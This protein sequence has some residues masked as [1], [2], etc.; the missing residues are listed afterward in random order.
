VQVAEAD[1][2]QL[3]GATQSATDLKDF[4]DAGYDP[5]TNKVEGVKLV[6][7]TT[8]NTDMLSTADID[9]RLAAINLDHL[10]TITGA[11]VTDVSNSFDTF[12][13]N[14]AGGTN[15]Y[16]VG[17]KILFLDGDNAGLERTIT[18]FVAATDFVTVDRDFPGVPADA[19]TFIVYGRAVAHADNSG[20]ASADVVAIEGSDPTDQI[21]AAVDAALDTAIPGTPTADSINE[22]IAAIDDLVQAAGGGDLAALWTRVQ[23]TT[24]ADSVLLDATQRTAIGDAVAAIDLAAG[25][26][27]YELVMHNGATIGAMLA[28]CRAVL[29]GAMSAPAATQKQY[30]EVDGA[31]GGANMVHA[32]DY[33]TRSAPTRP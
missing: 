28:I 16:Y 22:R 11:V 6:D 27:D 12:K 29:A 32:A 33:T 13:T 30:T 19:A 18:T 21:N 20:N 26:V 7:T 1:M 9:A 8:T 15:L 23:A 31:T 4:A 24:D 10:M 5:A 17:Q 25:S 2:V 3:G 14:L